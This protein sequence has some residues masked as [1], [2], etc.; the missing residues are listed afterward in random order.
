MIL[1]PHRNADALRRAMTE[2]TGIEPVFTGGVWVWDVRPL[3]K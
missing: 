3:T 1:G 2:L